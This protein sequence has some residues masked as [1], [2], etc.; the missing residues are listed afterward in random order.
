MWV[1]M[2]IFAIS[3][4]EIFPKGTY[5]FIILCSFHREILLSNTKITNYL[6]Y[7]NEYFNALSLRIKYGENIFL[8]LEVQYL[9]PSNNF[10]KDPKW[11]ERFHRLE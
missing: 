8:K 2:V 3:Y 6:L 5:S 1:D 7:V 4:K 11:G 9:L 10:I